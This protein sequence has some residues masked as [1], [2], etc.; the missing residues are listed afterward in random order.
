MRPEESFTIHIA[1]PIEM[2]KVTTKAKPS[3][4]DATWL[5]QTNAPD[6]QKIV[7][8]IP[9]ATPDDDYDYEVWVT[10][11]GMLDPRVRIKK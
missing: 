2:G 7:I 11:V 10:D 3:N 4:P 9:A 8:P 5:N 1:Q 6:S